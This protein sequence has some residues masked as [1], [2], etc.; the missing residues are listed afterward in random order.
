VPDLSM[1][2]PTY[3]ERERIEELVAELFRV[4]EG[5]LDLEV[6]IV[7]DNSPD[8][9]GAL[10]DALADTHR[11]HV[12]HRPGKMGLGGAVVAGAAAAR[13]PV[14]GIMDADFSHPPV[15]VPR[16]FA[17]FR[18]TGCDFL[19]ASRYVEGGST[20][21]WPVRRRALSRLGCLLSRPLTA[22][23]DATSGFFFLEAHVVRRA[24]LRE[25]GFKICLELLLRG[26]PELIVEA[27]YRFE[28]RAEGKS[29]MTGSEGRGYLRQ[30]AR[31][32]WE[33]ARRRPPPSR[34]RR[35]TPGEL[36]TL[37]MRPPGRKTV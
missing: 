34:Y 14:L 13:A 9:T 15:V 17:A 28:E 24:A 30:L 29:K 16:M 33:R 25:T 35:L 31:F 32:Y 12:V 6:V 20:F 11:V 8:G 1:I 37:A 3:N 5:I 19:V 10:A 18:A 2:V 36:D 23:R 27:P 4:C 7:D 26:R 21:D 22:V